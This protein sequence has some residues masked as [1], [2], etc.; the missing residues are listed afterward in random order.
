MSRR[1]RPLAALVF[2][3]L[4]APLGCSS[5]CAMLAERLC[6]CDQSIEPNR[7]ACESAS[8]KAGR[9]RSERIARQTGVDPQRVCRE[10]LRLFRCPA[11]R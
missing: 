6:A 10:A 9:A 5:P 8:D 2:I 7:R 4:A 3:A 1:L 11:E